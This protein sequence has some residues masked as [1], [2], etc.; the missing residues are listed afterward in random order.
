MRGGVVVETAA[1]DAIVG[2]ATAAHLYKAF[3]EL[4]ASVCGM[5]GGTGATREHVVRGKSRG[6]AR[7]PY[8]RGG[9]LAMWLVLCDVFA[10]GLE[11]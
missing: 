7:I 1:D 3:L 5:R 10:I 8:S 6:A 9:V 2:D 11:L 4:A